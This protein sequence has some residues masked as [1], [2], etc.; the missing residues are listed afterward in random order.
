MGIINPIRLPT[1]R[2][3]S[4]F[5]IPRDLAFDV[6]SAV[7]SLLIYVL[8][9]SLITL[10]LRRVSSMFRHFKSM[11]SVIL[12][13][14]GACI[15]AGALLVLIQIFVVVFLTLDHPAILLIEGIAAQLYVSCF[16]P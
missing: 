9:T 2:F 5:A 15:E 6:P 13:L 3:T 1:S 12:S 4:P 8:V 10:R 7:L 16:L 14:L 11:E